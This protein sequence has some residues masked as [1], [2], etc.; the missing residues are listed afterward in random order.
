[1]YL[2]ALQVLHGLFVSSHVSTID[3]NGADVIGATLRATVKRHM[4]GNDKRSRVAGGDAPKSPYLSAK[5][6]VHIRE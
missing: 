5:V 4:T 3:G 1:M 2:L 6:A